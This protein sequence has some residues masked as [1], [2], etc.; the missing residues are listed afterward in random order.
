MKY[1]FNLRF[2]IKTLYESF[3]ETDLLWGGYDE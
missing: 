2:D 1:Q 3:F